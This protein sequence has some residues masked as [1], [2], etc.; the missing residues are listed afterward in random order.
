MLTRIY[1]QRGF[2]LLGLA[3]LA[4]VCLF[5]HAPI[6][7]F[8]NYNHFADQHAW[9]GLPHAQNVLSNLPFLLVGIFGLIR[10]RR[11][12]ITSAIER[13]CWF[14]FFWG[15]SLT[16]FG[17]GFYHLQPDNW[18]LV[19][20][21]IPIILSF[22]F[23]FN[24]I[25]A[26]RISTRIAGATLIPFILYSVLAV[27]YWYWT[28]SL[29]VGDM[30]AYILVQML[31]L[32]LLPFILWLFEAKYTHGWMLLAV[33]LWYLCA[34]FCEGFDNEIYNWT[35]F[36]SGHVLKHLFAGLACAQ[37]AWMLE[38]RRLIGVAHVS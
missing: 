6:A 26:E 2:F 29:G 15:V 17:S 14:G 3:V 18:R 16:A 32:L 10:L 25:I 30:R 4:T 1:N 36:I 35:G 9:L 12:T 21:R 28:Q 37:V 38:K 34:K 27:F 5:M 11:Y 20:D 13:L 22:I 31:P 19:W 7:Q 24:A 8:A 23:L 33:A